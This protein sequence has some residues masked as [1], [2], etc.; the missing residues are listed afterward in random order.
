[1]VLKDIMAISGQPGLYRFIAQGKNAIIVEHLETKIRSSAFSSARVSSL[2]EISVFT[3]EEDLPLGKVLDR[4]HEKENGGPALDSKTDP[5]GLKSWFEEILPT[6]NREKV[7]VSDIRKIAQWYNILHKLNLLVKEEPDKKDTPEVEAQ[8]EGEAEVKTEVKAEGEA[9][10][11]GTSEDRENKIEENT[12]EKNPEEQ[13][14]RAKKQKPLV[15]NKEVKAKTGSKS[16]K[17]QSKP[18][19]K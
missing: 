11:A 2:E 19:S 4:I 12:V 7:Y 1:M 16:G 18:E 6:Y 8:A 10:A 17:K 9:E 15:S 13:K 14:S 3:E 5:E